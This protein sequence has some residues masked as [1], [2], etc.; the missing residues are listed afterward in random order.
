MFQVVAPVQ[1]S[2]KPLSAGTYQI[3]WDGMG[4]LVQ[5]NI[6]QG[7]KA[8]VSVP[9]KIF[10]LNMKSP[11]DTPGTRANPDGSLSLQSLRFA[12]QTFALYFSGGAE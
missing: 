11:S 4:P 1:V 5:V 12:G 10:L 6:L 8:I 7:G 9:A 2:G 3:T